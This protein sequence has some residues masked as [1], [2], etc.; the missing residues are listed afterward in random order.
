[1][2]LDE[3]PEDLSNADIDKLESE[4][5]EKIIGRIVYAASLSSKLDRAKNITDEE[6]AERQQARTDSISRAKERL[7]RIGLDE[8]MAVE[9]LREYLRKKGWSQNERVRS[10]RSNM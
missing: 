10:L 3:A 7:K 4:L 1:M 5:K 6:Y 2:V 8:N 9:A